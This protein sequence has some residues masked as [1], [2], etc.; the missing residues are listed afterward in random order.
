MKNL[1]NSAD[2]AGFP[3]TWARGFI[4]PGS[5]GRDPTLVLHGG[6]NTSV[7]TREKNIFGEEEALLR[8][9]GS[10]WTW[11]R[12][13]RPDSRRAGWPPAQARGPRIALGPAHGRRA[14]GVHD[15]P[16]RADAS[17]EAILHAVLPAKF[18]D[19]THADALIAVTNTPGGEGRVREIYGDT[20][21]VIPYVMPGFK[22]ARLFAETF[23][24]KASRRT[25]GVVL[26][27][28]GLISFGDTAEESYGRMIE[29]VTLAEDL[30]GEAQ[31]LDR[32]MAAAMP[33]AGAAR[34]DRAAAFRKRALRGDGRPGDPVDPRRCPVSRLCDAGPTWPRFPSRGRPRPTMSSARSGC[35]LSGATFRGVPLGLRGLF[36]ACADRVSPPPT[37]LDP[38]PR[39]ILDPEWGMVS[40]GRTARE[41]SIVNDLYRHTIDI[42]MRSAALGGWK[43][44]PAQDI[45]DVEYWDLEQA[46]LRRHGPVPVFQGEVALVTG[47]ASGIGRACVDSLL[48]RGAAV[49]GLDVNPDIAGMHKR[50][51]FHGIVCDLTEEAGGRRGARGGGPRVRRP[52]HAGP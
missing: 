3:A 24:R 4:R 19:H 6:G 2:A 38:A 43:A 14:Q 13:R 33:G 26:M 45:F 11:P 8:V 23:P 12:S 18:V 20:V 17:V 42:I 49:V 52:R 1:W 34:P 5:S 36:Q 27:N 31:G 10:G 47:A 21:V 30:P 40:V 39:V 25:V 28:H 46:K 7:K 35:R 16:V 50:P 44:L 9:K 15:R 48:R 41:A 37:L 22:L 29:L 32:R 51:D